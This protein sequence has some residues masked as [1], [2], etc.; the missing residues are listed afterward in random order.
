VFPVTYELNSYIVFRSN[1]TG[2]IVESRVRQS[3][4][5]ETMEKSESQL[6]E[7]RG[8]HTDTHSYTGSD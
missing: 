4:Q 8:T 2:R 5:N 6:V 1:I 7:A 3:E